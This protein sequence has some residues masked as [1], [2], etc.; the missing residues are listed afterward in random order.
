[1]DL[2]AMKLGP[3][4]DL[5][6]FLVFDALN[7]ELEI[8]ADTFCI[9]GQFPNT[10]LNGLEAK[11]KGYLGAV[12]NRDAMPDQIQQVL[13]AFGPVLGEYRYRNAFSAEVRVVEGDGYFIDPC[14]RWP[15]PG[16]GATMELISNLPKII[17]AGA[18][19][20]L[21]EPQMTAKFAAECVLTA[22]SDKHAWSVLDFTDQIKPFVKCGDSCEIDGRICFPPH[23][24]HGEEIGWL[25]T[26]GDTIAAT[27]EAMKERVKLLPD[28][29]HA[30]TEAIFDL[31][32]EAIA[33][34]AQDIPFA[35]QPIPEPAIALEEKSS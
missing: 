22:K 20:E 14:C 6:T 13:A 31:L 11:D 27:V 15:I 17:V 23:E 10:M 16:S 25:V 4:K 34:E 33:S 9:D 29:V 32:K 21:V 24:G 19:G 7:T 35:D 28:G 12:M 30:C 2:L 1:M 5:M 26:T 18:A 8:G 3:S